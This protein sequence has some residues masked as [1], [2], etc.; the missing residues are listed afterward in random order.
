MTQHGEPNKFDGLCDG[1][2]NAIAL[3]HNSFKEASEICQIKPKYICIVWR[4]YSLGRLQKIKS[5]HC[6]ILYQKWSK[7]V[8]KYWNRRQNNRFPL[9]SVTKK[10]RLD[11]RWNGNILSLYSRKAH[12]L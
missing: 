4:L 7:P 12:F 1:V 9:Q 8:N 6:C 5:S 11:G 2:L 10:F 3:V